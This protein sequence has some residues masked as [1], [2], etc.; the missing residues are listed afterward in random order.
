M[1]KNVKLKIASFALIFA[2]SLAFAFDFGGTATNKSSLEKFNEEN[3]QLNQKNSL[4]IWAR[5]NFDKSAENYF[6]AEASYNFET[7]FFATDFANQTFT[8]ALDFSLLKFAYTKN[9][10]FGKFSLNAGRFYFSDLSGIVFSQNAD[11]IKFDFQNDWIKTSIYSSYT[12]LLN[13]LTTEMITSAATSFSFAQKVPVENPQ[14]AFSSD[15]SKVYDLAQKYL[16]A[17]FDFSLP[18]LIANQSVALEYFAAFKLE[19]ETFNRMYASVNFN[20]PIYSSFFYDFSTSFAFTN[21]AGENK[22]SN[23]SKANLK[24]YFMNFSLGANAIYASGNQGFLSTFQGFTK[25]TSTYSR[26]D[27]LYSGI[28]KAGVNATYKPIPTLLLSFDC[29]TIFNASAG[30]NFDKIEYFAFQYSLGA[31]WQIKSD[32]Q[33]GLSGAQFLDAE[34]SNATRKSFV[35]L[36][37]IL[38]F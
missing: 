26:Q 2:S 6:A 22:I 5:Q 31:T 3:L 35:C 25:N 9:F 11:G 21:Y 19:G 8:N 38:A 1:I 20:G 29:D 18:N 36:N 28:L 13:A 16:I 7:D 24:Y 10:D 4:S 12:G 32:F 14:N 27:F 23:L 34:N 15:S 33:L 17:A 30:N 37:A